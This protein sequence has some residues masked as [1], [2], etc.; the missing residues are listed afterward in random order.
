M[1]F[2][3]VAGLSRFME[4]ATQEGWTWRGRPIEGF[5]IEDA[6]GFQTKLKLDFYAY[7]KRMRTLKDRIGK[8]RASGRPLGRDLSEPRV[9]HFHD[10]AVTQPIELLQ[11]DIVAVRAAYLEQGGVPLEAPPVEEPDVGAAE[12][13]GFRAMLESLQN[14]GPDYVLRGSTA[15]RVVALALQD[16]R[17]LQALSEAAIRVR[18]VLAATQGPATEELAERIGLDLG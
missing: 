15:D 18:L 11:R 2:D 8:T 16:D 13:V 6:Q 1:R 14:K 9:Q 17:K 5:V 12:V 7:W 4:L 10:W 3:D